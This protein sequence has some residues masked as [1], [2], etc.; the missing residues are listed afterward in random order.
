MVPLERLDD[1][2][3]HRR[4]PVPV[5]VDGPVEHP[6]YEVRDHVPNERPRRRP[7]RLEG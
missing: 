4:V 3:E 2:A 7:Q 1:S 6:A 5:V